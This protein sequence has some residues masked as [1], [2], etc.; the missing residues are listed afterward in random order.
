MHVLLLTLALL[1]IAAPG[2]VAQEAVHRAAQALENDTVYV[3]P[4][5]ERAVSPAEADALRRRI[6][7]EAVDLR[8]AIL[9][10]SAGRPNDV[11]R[12]LSSQLGG[13]VA[14]VVGNA[15]RVDGSP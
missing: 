10:G 6:E 8:I 12:D 5:A 14:T 15:F 1:L 2:A 11:T 7:D 13:S 4:Q 9:P 3:D